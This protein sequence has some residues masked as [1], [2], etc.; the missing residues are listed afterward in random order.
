MRIASQVYRQYLV[1]KGIKELAWSLLRK[2]L[3]KFFNDPACSMMIHGRLLNLPLSHQLPAVM[4]HCRFYDKLPKRI[5]EYIHRYNGRVIC[6]DVGANIGDTIASLYNDETD[7]FLAIEPSE[8][9]NKFL[10]ENWSWNKGVFFVDDICSAVSSE[11]MFKFENN[12]GTSRV[13]KSEGGAKIRQR[14]LD[15]ILVDHPAFMN[16]NFLKIDTDGY[17]FEVI[18]GAE[19]FLSQNTPMVLFECDAFENSNYVEDCM[20]AM[21]FFKKCGYN[22]FLLYND[23]GNLMGKHSL[24]DLTAFK[25]LLFFEMT[26]NIFVFDILVMKDDD[27]FQFY[28][29]EIGY[30]TDNMSNK[31][32]KRT[33]IVAT[34]MTL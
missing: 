25:S 2:I 22:Y 23:L 15:D 8:K 33:A 4:K 28:K 24:N 20:T 34:E 19:R 11:D 1:S 16:A 13:F 5:A 29:S 14:K 31:S 3:I 21:K 6:I 32:L 12:R 30:Y 10:T 26:S 18:K 27:V 7:L 17:D 9:F